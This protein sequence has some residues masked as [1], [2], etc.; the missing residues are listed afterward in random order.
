VNFTF[1]QADVLTVEIEPTDLLFIDTWHVAQQ[2][3][4]ELRLHGDRSRRYLVLH[5][6]ETF[7]EKGETAGHGGIWPAIAAFVRQNPQWHLLH[8]FPHSN[9]LTVLSRMERDGDVG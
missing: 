6:T 7:G 5:D 8:H 1:H 2:I 9:G 3:Q 4:E